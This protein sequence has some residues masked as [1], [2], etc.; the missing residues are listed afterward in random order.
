MLNFERPQ[1]N[2]WLMNLFPTKL[3]QLRESK[4][5]LQKDIAEYLAIDTPQYCRIEKGERRAR[6]EQV[7]DLAEY[8]NVDKEDLLLLWLADQV[9]EVLSEDKSIAK[10]V[11]YIADSTFNL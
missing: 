8:L 10:Q 5:L 7:I 3:H 4:N 9:K 1:R 2:F 11:F 6:R